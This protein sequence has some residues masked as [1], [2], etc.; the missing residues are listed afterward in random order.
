MNDTLPTLSLTSTCIDALKKIH[1][2]NP[3]LSVLIIL[4][5][6]HCTKAAVAE[7]VGLIDGESLSF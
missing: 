7:V 1:L 5:N 4:V 2:D 3:F 6:P